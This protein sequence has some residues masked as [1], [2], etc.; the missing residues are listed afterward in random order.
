MSPRLY[1]ITTRNYF[2]IKFVLYVTCSIHSI[3]ERYITSKNAYPYS[4]RVDY[5]MIHRGASWRCRLIAVSSGI[6]WILRFP[7]ARNEES[8]LCL[9]AKSCSKIGSLWPISSALP[10]GRFRWF[11]ISLLSWKGSIGSGRPLNRLLDSSFRT[12]CIS[13]R[14]PSFRND[15]AR[16]NGSN[17]RR[18]YVRET[19]F[20][21]DSLVMWICCSVNMCKTYILYMLC[22]SV[23]P[24]L[25]WS[26]QET[27]KFLH[28]SH[29]LTVK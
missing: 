24:F 7:A 21:R 26:R 29:Q 15:T 6:C 18:L 11:C 5:S 23:R 1:Q 28:W 27:V 16:Q 9:C 19:M 8:I 2:I 13:L 10:W 3:W 20:M 4:I 14:G 17:R 12:C 25:H 22:G